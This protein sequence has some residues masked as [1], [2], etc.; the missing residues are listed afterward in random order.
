M[1]RGVFVIIIAHVCCAQLFAVVRITPVYQGSGNIAIQYDATGESELVR[2]FALDITVNGGIIVDVTDFC[3]GPDNG[4]YG[5]FPGNFSRFISVDP[6][7]GEVEDWGMQG[8]TPVADGNAPGA[9]PGLGSY[10]VTLE[11]GSL[12]D[13]Q[14]P[15]KTG[16]LCKLTIEDGSYLLMATNSIRG[17]VVL[18]NGKEAVVDFDQWSPPPPFPPSYS[19]YND[20][21]A[22]G[23]PTCW[24]SKEWGGSGY[25]CDG[26]ADGETKGFPKYR[27]TTNDLCILGENWHKRINDPTLNPCADFDHKA[28]GLLKFRVGTNDL[29]ILV[30][31][32]LKRDKDLPGDC[33]RPE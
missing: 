29:N 1:N 8:Y 10:G 28:Q 11:M 32:W 23:K 16:V 13:T 33:P 5:I 18:E 31:N 30:N 14:A 15:G 24:T 22:L 9:L 27:I 7:T 21:V 19:T 25:Q 12:Y 4:G 17:G 20:W 26:D 2:S 6:Q 3:V